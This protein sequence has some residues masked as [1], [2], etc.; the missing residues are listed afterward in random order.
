[1][2]KI[3]HIFNSIE[4]SGAE[5]MIFT[6]H[7]FYNTEFITYAISTGVKKGEFYN[8]FSQKFKCFHIPVAC[9]RNYQYFVNL[10]ELIRFY[11]TEKIDIVHIH[12]SRRFVFHILAA[13]FGGVKKTV[14][15]IHNNFEFEG[16][17]KIKEILSRKFAKFLNI[18][19]VSISDSV[20]QNELIRFN[21]KTKLV[22]NFYNEDVIFP[23][24]ISEKN[25]LR[26]TMGIANDAFAL[27]S[28]G[29]CCE[30]KQHKHIIEVVSRLKERIPNI[31]YFHLG[32]GEMEGEEKSLCLKLNIMDRVLFAGNVNNI[33]DYLV[34]SDLY[35]LTSK[36]EGLS[37]AT[38]E[39][40]GAGIPVILYDTAGTR[41]LGINGAPGILVEPNANALEEKI[42]E[43]YSSKESLD[44]IAKTSMEFVKGTYSKKQ[45]IID[46]K[47]IYFDRK[48]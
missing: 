4:Y 12:P 40:M 48:H 43:M 29:T 17:V 9:K 20:Y 19:T 23:E 28:V 25:D 24:I 30:R 44:L 35:L 11:R 10:F 47:N 45:A 34:S 32:N 5:R 14:R 46:W 8:K 16:A 27:V 15:Q 31:F 41:D 22:Y 18:E 39:A 21:N 26:K 42:F 38:I 37:I 3:A 36:I 33:R 1:M 7:E 2:K 6:L 13:K